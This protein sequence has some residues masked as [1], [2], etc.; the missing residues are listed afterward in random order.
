MGTPSFHGAMMIL[1]SFAVYVRLTLLHRRS[2]QGLKA[3]NG[4][5]TDTYLVTFFS[6]FKVRVLWDTNMGTLTQFKTPSGLSY[7]GMGTITFHGTMILEA[8]QVLC[9][10]DSLASPL[11]SRRQTR[12]GSHTDYPIL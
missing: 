4:S 5:H 2:H 10:I 1:E 9:S 7:L 6:I 12:N 3:R 8:L 11:P